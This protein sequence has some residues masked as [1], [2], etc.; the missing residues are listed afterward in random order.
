MN[1]IKHLTG[2]FE[3]IIQDRS[4]NPTH[5][6]LYIALFQSWNINR[7]QNPISISRDEVM[8]ICKI[9]SKAT[10]HKCM[11]DL[12]EKGYV[13]YEP[14]FNPY[15]G[16]MVILF[17][18]SDYLK[19]VQKRASI[20]GKNL[21]KNE[22]VMN[23]QE[24][25]NDTSTGTSSEQAL[26]SYINNTNIT[27]KSNISKFEN[28]GEQAKNF[29]EINSSDLKNKNLEKEK[30]SVKKE[31]EEMQNENAAFA[32]TNEKQTEE[33]WQ[34]KMREKK[35]S[36]L[37]SPTHL[38]NNQKIVGNNFSGPSSTVQNPT[39]DEVKSYFFEQNF[40]KIEAVKFFNYFSSIGWLVGGKTPMVDWQAAAQNWM[41]NAIKFRTYEKPPDRAKHL[42][43]ENDKD[44][45]EPL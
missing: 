19:P 44:Y 40:P 24:T 41:L 33:G 20:T 11:R 28:L 42:N 34:K 9:S 21:S 45:G 30:S 32:N 15:K 23:K 4:L 1:Y 26:V 10:Y 13:K 35:K 27:N 16:S 36:F 17:D 6:S 18:F 3:R 39:Q 2:F 12:N 5:V 37:D 25:S 43:T 14:S 38:K 7:F 29:E 8:R 31:K 22:Q